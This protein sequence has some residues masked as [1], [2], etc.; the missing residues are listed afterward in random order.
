MFAL[1]SDFTAFKLFKHRGTVREG[2]HWDGTFLLKDLVLLS[3]LC[4]T[5]SQPMGKAY[6][7]EA[8]GQAGDG[9][10]TMAVL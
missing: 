1:H 5:T 7:Y 9:L 6:M 3:E 10:H 8:V 2:I 4:Q